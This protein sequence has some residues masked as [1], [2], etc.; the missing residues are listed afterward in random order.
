MTLEPPQPP[1]APAPAIRP[2]PPK[3]PH[4]DRTPF[5]KD[6][7]SD[8]PQVNREVETPE[9][10]ARDAV[11]NGSGALTRRTVDRNDEPQNVAPSPRRENPLPADSQSDYDRGQDVL[12]QFRALDAQEAQSTYEPPARPSA[13]QRMPDVPRINHNE[14]HG[15][16]FWL[17]TL[18]FVAVATFIIA[19]NFLFT[20]KPA[21]T[22]AELF[23]D[24]EKATTVKPSPKP[25]EK[26]IAKPVAKPVAK[27]AVKSARTTEKSSVESPPKPVAKPA[28]TPEK[29]SD[30]KRPRFEVRV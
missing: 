10:M 23:D 9:T 20:G 11:A 1:T 30:E 6:S 18:V 25:V 7:N 13:E 21:L 15:G 24:K 16:I 27:P 4:I 3:P 8:T 5:V 12:R 14:G 17:F 29:K 28:R 19:K 26:S 22:K 2:T